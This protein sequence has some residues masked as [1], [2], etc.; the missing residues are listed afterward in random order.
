MKMFI[1]ACVFGL[2]GAVNAATV[3]IGPETCSLTRLCFNVPND[4]AL[5]IEYLSNAI[6]YR[7]LLVQIDGDLYDSGLWAL[8][9]QL[10]QTN[11]VLYDPIGKAITVTLV[12]TDVSNGPCHQNGRVAVCPRLVTLQS[13]KI[14]MQ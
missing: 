14:T 11:V 8:N 10:N 7:R 13:G 6:Q 2:V 1:A 12:M 9:G 3:N 5:T 4:G